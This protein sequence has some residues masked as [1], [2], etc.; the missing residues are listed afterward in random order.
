MFNAYLLNHT[1]CT[2]YPQFTSNEG[3][4]ATRAFHRPN[5]RALYGQRRPHPTSWDGSE[6]RDSLDCFP[7]ENLSRWST[8]H[9]FDCRQS[10]PPTWAPD[11][12]QLVCPRVSKRPS[13][14]RQSSSFPLAP[15]QPL[16]LRGFHNTHGRRRG[17]LGVGH[18]EI[19]SRVDVLAK[20]AFL[21]LKSFDG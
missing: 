4:C 12:G 8:C 11:E 3:V 6:L 2:L 1:C 17:C 13:R 15:W 9:S 18:M 16:A 14:E 5:R 10:Q 21:I 7:T 19:S 20:L